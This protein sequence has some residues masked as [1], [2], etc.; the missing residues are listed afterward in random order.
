MEQE[1]QQ[2]GLTEANRRKEP[3]PYAFAVILPRSS[4][5][6]ET[7]LHSSVGAL[8]PP[9]GSEEKPPKACLSSWSCN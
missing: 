9:V 4:L 8:S 2:G 5:A 7:W 1:S 6:P 3:S